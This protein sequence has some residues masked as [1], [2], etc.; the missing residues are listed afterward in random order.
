MSEINGRRDL[1]VL[2]GG[3]SPEYF[4]SCSSG[5][6]LLSAI[7]CEQW[8][9]SAVG[10]TQE[11]EWLLTEAPLEEIAD[12]KT[13]LQHES[14]RKAVLSPDRKDHA[15]LVMNE[16]AFSKRNVDVVFPIIHGE[17][18]EDGA[19]EGLFQ[20]SGIP[21]VGCDVCSS[22]CGMDKSVSMIFS[23]LCGIKR[24][25]YYVCQSAAYQANPQAVT[26]DIVR[27]FT[28]C[29]GDTIYPLF[30]K[31]AT[32]G[33]SIGISKVE[34]AEAM[35]EALAAA[36]P[37]SK[38]IIIEQGIKG[39]EVKIAVLGNENP[40]VGDPCE[41][42]VDGIFNDYNM[43]YKVHDSHKKI[44]AELPEDV[45]A[46]IKAQSVA[47]YSAMGCSGFARVDF[48]LTD[49]MEIIFNEINTVPGFT[50]GSIYPLMF[51]SQGMTY[52]ELVA[53][54]LETANK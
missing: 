38:K 53:K 50:R 2:F 7:D 40:V 12:G 34:N 29:L 15:L 41:V 20:V 37:Y 42:V 25:E 3:A 26:D 13:W 16:G 8:N 28:A 49:D 22:S 43:K 21:Y 27:H 51:A 11:G 6:A 39:R 52:E 5:A 44:P 35:N 33:S 19:L 18:G 31:P 9:V 14:N 45:I 48:F 4:V 32:T 36:A 23:D 30:V 46:E 17:T 10:I 1:L 47:L 24:P 54:L